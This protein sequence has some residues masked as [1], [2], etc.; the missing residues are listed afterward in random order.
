MERMIRKQ[1]YIQRRHQDILSRRAT[2]LNVTEAEVVR[3]AIEQI[4]Q[5]PGRF[6]P[7]PQAWANFLAR[8]EERE[9]TRYPQQERS[10][11]RDELYEERFK[12]FSS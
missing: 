11:T 3:R 12:R 1:V 9:K 5:V 8:Q 6:V 7:D 2:E 10:W 4:E